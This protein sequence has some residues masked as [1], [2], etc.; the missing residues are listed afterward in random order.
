MDQAHRPG[1]AAYW[2]TAIWFGFKA[3]IVYRLS[4]WLGPISIVTTFLIQVMIW[5]ALLGGG[6]R[7]GT[8]FEEMLTFAVITQFMSGLVES[9]SGNTLSRLIRTGDIVIY[10]VRPIRLKQHLFLGDLGKNLFTAFCLN[11]P[12]FVILLAVWGGVFP[13]DPRIVAMSA[14][15]LALGVVMLFHYRYLLGLVSFWLIQNPFT[16]W[17][18]QNAETIL[19][20]NV[21]P[22]WLCPAWLSTLTL[23]LPFRYFTYEPIALFIGKTRLEDAGRVLLIQLLWAAALV[24]LERVVSKRAI[25]KLVVQG[26]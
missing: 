23:F 20:G 7:F 11:G 9:F 19:S 16:S 21:L 18:F 3:R 25:N 13:Q 14:L 17:H 2:L 6:A 1:R 24:L 8:T 15:M 5:R 12:V 22:L 10:L 4:A 26:G